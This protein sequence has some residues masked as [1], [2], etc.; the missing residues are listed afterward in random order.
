LR[1]AG[2]AIVSSLAVEVSQLY[3]SP[4]I[5]AIRRTAVGGLLLGF[6]FVWSDLVCYAVGIGLGMLG[7]IAFLDD[8]SPPET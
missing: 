7:E 8:R 6:G 1:V 4:W 2:L 5:D 3:H